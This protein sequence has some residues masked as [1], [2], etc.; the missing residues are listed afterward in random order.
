MMAWPVPAPTQTRRSTHAEPPPSS[1]SER[2][3]DSIPVQERSPFALAQIT[4]HPRDGFIARQTP[5]PAAPQQTSPSAGAP[6]TAG[7]S[8]LTITQEPATGL[9]VQ[10]LLNKWRAR[11]TTPTA[12]KM[13]GTAT[14]PCSAGSSSGHEV[15]IHQVLT[16]EV[17]NARYRGQTPADGSLWIRRD[18]PA[19]RKAPPCPDSP[20]GRFWNA[21]KPAACGKAARVEHSDFPQ[22]MYSTIETNSKTGKP[23]YLAELHLDFQFT[24][25]LMHKKPDASLRTLRWLE[26]G[27]GWDYTFDTPGS[28]ESKVLRGL[29]SVSSMTFVDVPAIPAELPTRYAVPAKN[30]NT[31]SMEASD[32]PASHEAK[33]TW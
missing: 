14:V 4:V 13:V 12:I 32:N 28:G 9:Q 15:G 2:G 7:T 19:V 6:A 30:C 25:A 26:W 1:R 5:P 10:N 18:I 29:A 17:N 22:D 33:N 3:E 31:L 23:N 11:P 20:F 21:S 8:S 24:T 27:V 16:S